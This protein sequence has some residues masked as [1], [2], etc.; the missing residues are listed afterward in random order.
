MSLD[1]KIAPEIKEPIDFKISLPLVQKATLKNGVDVYYLDMGTEEAIQISWMFYAGSWNEDKKSQAGATNF[2]LKNG[3]SEKS[4]FE[5]NEFF[6]YYGA[7]LNRTCYTETADLTLHTL[8]KHVSVLLPE[9]SKLIMDAVFPEEELALFKQNSVQRLKVNL[10]KS[11][12]VA[13]RLIDALI[14]GEEHPYGRYNNAED[15]TALT[16]EDLVSFYEKNYKQG[17]CAIFLAG[18]L[19]KGI[20]EELDQHFGSLPFKNHR[21]YKT[22]RIYRPTPAEQ[23]KHLIIN[24]E[25]G[26]QAAIRIARP[27]PDRS[28]PDFQPALLLNT[29]FG[30]FFGS[31]L[32]ANIRE[33]KGYTYGIYSYIQNHLGETAWMVSTEAGRDVA[34]ATVEEVYKEM[35]L[36]CEEP[37][38][39]EELLTTKNYMI[40]SILGDLDGAF[41]VMARWRNLLLNNLDEQYFYTSLQTIKNASPE[42]LMELANK[43]LKPEAFHELVVI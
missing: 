34:E 32:M 27:F 28:N 39:D 16:R 20:L 25:K 17:Y 4:A 6:E 40:G 13:G 22:T 43:Y 23:K 15:Y 42:Y 14:Y 18:K 8:N 10:T 2:M 31:R 11:D 41:Q 21:E 12:F 30:G 24:D 1:R 36:L 19:P 9:V 3:T 5:I 35:K 37:V 26:V 7:Y 33:E 38:D 29:L